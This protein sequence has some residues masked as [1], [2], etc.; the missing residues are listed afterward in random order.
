MLRVL[1]GRKCEA[2]GKGKGKWE[3]GKKGE[4]LYAKV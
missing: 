2:K 3:E 1:L 4:T